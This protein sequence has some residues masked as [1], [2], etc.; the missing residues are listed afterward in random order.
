M[1]KKI[2]DFEK[3]N[4]KLTKIIKRSLNFVFNPKERGFCHHF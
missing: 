2:Y 3:A 4:Y 1:D